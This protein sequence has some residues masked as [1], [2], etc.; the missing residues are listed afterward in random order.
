MG[1]F[2]RWS[3]VKTAAEMSLPVGLGMFPL[4]LALGLLVVQTG[5]DWWVS[6]G[7]S[8]FGYAG[9]LEFFMIE[10]MSTHTA[11]LTIAITTFFV[12]FRHVFYTFSFPL[13]VVKNPVAKLYSMYSMTD[14]AY[15]ITV[16]HPQGWNTWR[17]VSLQ[18]FLQSYWVAGG[19]TGVFLG[20]LIP[21]PIEGLEFAL[22]ALFI[23]L[24]LDAARTREHIPSVLLAA[25]AFGVAA[26]AT[27]DS[28]IFT[29]MIVFSLLLS[30]RFIFS[31]RKAGLYL[32]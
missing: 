15:A 30:L 32:E 21:A 23:T 9:S 1:K 12:N 2:S 5:F 17:L 18:A 16:A 28:V 25:V 26:V 10:L 24:A 14:E 31:R 11:L 6:P 4:G 27:P 22:V 20:S 8:T 29:G 3:E 13:H 7:L 19:L